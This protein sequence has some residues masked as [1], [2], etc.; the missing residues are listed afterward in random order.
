MT[1][2][3]NVNEARGA[4]SRLLDRVE[5]GEEIE[6]TRYGRVVAVLVRPDRLHARRARSA[7]ENAAVAVEQRLQHA[8]SGEWSD[9]DMI[10]EARALELVVEIDA[11]RSRRMQ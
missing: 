5:V 3:V 1:Y 4:L 10:T 9:E 2:R 7:S 11:E 6:L 8:R